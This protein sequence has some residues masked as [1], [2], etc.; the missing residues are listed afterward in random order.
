MLD[1]VVGTVQSMTDKAESLLSWNLKSKGRQT[2]ELYLSKWVL[3][4]V[5][6]IFVRPETISVFCIPIIY[7]S[8]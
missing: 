6:N 1:I 4:A 7:Y 8:S 5:I 2:H 3:S